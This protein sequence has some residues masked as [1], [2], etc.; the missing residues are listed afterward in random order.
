MKLAFLETLDAIL[1]RG[2]FV[3]AAE[4]I[5]VTPS[6]VSLQVKRLEEHFGQPLFV[7]AARVAQPTP[8]ARQLAQTVRE[9]LA[10]VEGLRL[11]PAPSVSGG[12]VLG[13]IRTVQ[14]STLPLALR[15]LRRRY[16]DL[17]VR[18]VQADSG[19]LIDHLKTGTIDAAVI[20]GPTSR[21]RGRFHWHTLGRE[22]F[23]L[24][25]PPDS[26]DESVASLV[27]RYDWIQFD[28]T[29]I[30]GRMVAR[31]LKRIAPQI[32]TSVEID[33]I[34][35]IVALV[36]SGYG[37]SIVPKPQQPISMLHPVREIALPHATEPRRIEFV[38]RAL[39]VD[40]RRVTALRDAFVEVYASTHAGEAAE[41]EPPGGDARPARSTR[42][43]A[44]LSI[45]RPP[46]S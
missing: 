25:A 34:D 44:P 29:L 18:A 7:R 21:E 37:I 15:Q 5:G 19:V 28:R 3:A 33:S 20:V 42:R 40:N 36:S 12:V 43:P 17:V 32:R 46:S 6:A 30:S 27:R 14:S 45:E 41:D 2:S 31:Y 35:A 22:P 23:V 4:E 24:I 26:P 8:F 10:T 9:T 16:P 1:R 13:T 39:D 11:R 38:S